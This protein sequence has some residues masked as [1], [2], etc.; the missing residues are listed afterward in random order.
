M[1]GD[2]E[3]PLRTLA[4]AYAGHPAHDRSQVLLIAQCAGDVVTFMRPSEDQ[5]G[6]PSRMT[7]T[8]PGQGASIPAM[9]NASSGDG[10]S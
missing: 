2:D 4:G 10:D 1:T 5:I 7:S 6:S 9:G 8:R 3:R